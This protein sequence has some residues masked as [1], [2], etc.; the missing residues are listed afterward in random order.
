MLIWVFEGLTVT[1]SSSPSS[2][3]VPLPPAAARKARAESASQKRRTGRLREPPIILR[4]T[5]KV[6]KAVV[7]RRMKLLHDFLPRVMAFLLGREL[8]EHKTDFAV[9]MS[10][11]LRSES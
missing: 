3:F 9:A 7:L 10:S 6:S 1:A 5:Q 4:A 11:E 8:L 2:N